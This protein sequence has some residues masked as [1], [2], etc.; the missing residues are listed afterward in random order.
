L[1]Q[2]SNRAAVQMLNTIGIPQ[3][4]AYAQKLNVGTPPSVPSLALGASD[5]TLLSL[6]AAYA[7]FANQGMLPTPRL[8]RRVED[9]D[10]KVLYQDAGNSQRV[11]SPATAFLMSSMLADV[12][13]S[14][15]AY[16]ARQAGFTLP[17]AGKTGTTNDYVDA[18]F[19]GFTPTLATGVWVGFDQPRTIVRNGYAA[20]LAVPIWSGFMKTATRSDKPEWFEK[21]ANVVGVNVC[22]ISGKLPSYGCSSVETI[23]QDGFAEIKSQVYTDFFVKGTQPASVCPLHT[24]GVILADAGMPGVPHPVPTSGTAPP[25]VTVGDPVA[26]TPVPP[27]RG[28][29]VPPP[30]PP[31]KGFWRRIFGGGGGRGG[32]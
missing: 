12:I 13:N 17:A 21:P 4:V 1:K 22:R 19:V 5:V 9:S 3:A 25:P 29:T 16:K 7:T 11:V 18:W 27:L 6:T 23:D 15:T 2:S 32:G 24:G 30:A 20:E 8:I 14:G 10:G 31:K 28:G 26:V